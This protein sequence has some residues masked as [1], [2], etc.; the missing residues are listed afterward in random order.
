MENIEMSVAPFIKLIE[1]DTIQKTLILNLVEPDGRILQIGDTIPLIPREDSFV[2]NL[3]DE[4]LNLWFANMSS[5][6][7][8]LK[9]TE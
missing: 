8:T 1:I 2:A 3:P 7:I 4:F 9:F 5:E 6:T